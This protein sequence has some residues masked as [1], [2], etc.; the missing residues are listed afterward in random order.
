MAKITFGLQELLDIV[1]SNQFLPRQIAR[2]RVKGDRVHFV[3]KTN[4]FILPFIPASLGYQSFDGSHAIF[5]FT[6]VSGHVNKAIGWLH[7]A[8]RVQM[9]AF[10]TL[11]YPKVLIDIDR[12][13][14]E[15]NIKGIQVKDIVFENGQFAIVT[16][17]A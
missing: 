11:D 1:V 10:V 12:L 7:E 4:S 14:R 3:I 17:T 8:L 5:E 16:D 9:P 13:L 15:K 6:L 2:L